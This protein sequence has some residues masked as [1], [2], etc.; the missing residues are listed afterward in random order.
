MRKAGLKFP[1]DSRSVISQPLRDAQS[2]S[3]STLGVVPPPVQLDFCA[4]TPFELFSNLLPSHVLAGPLPLQRAETERPDG[5]SDA[6]KYVVLTVSGDTV[7]TASIH[8]STSVLVH[9]FHEPSGGV[10]EV[11]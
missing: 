9:Q 5:N 10:V 6:E 3:I 8:P 11:A 2:I 7:V 4:H 1:V